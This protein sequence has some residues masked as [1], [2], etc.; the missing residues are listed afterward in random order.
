MKRVWTSIVTV[1]F[2]VLTKSFNKS[3]YPNLSSEYP[4]AYFFSN[5]KRKT[6][7]VKLS[8]YRVEEDPLWSPKRGI[9][10]PYFQFLFYFYL[11]Y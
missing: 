5:E 3:I 2:N 1:F 10:P 6:E 7:D 11:F 4:F 9:K 8:K